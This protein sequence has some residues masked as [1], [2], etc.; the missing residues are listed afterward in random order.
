MAYFV[1]K[2]PTFDSSRFDMF[3]TIPHFC[4]SKVGGVMNERGLNGCVPHQHSPVAMHHRQTSHHRHSGKRGMEIIRLPC[5]H[6]MLRNKRII[7][8]RSTRFAYSHSNC[9]PPCC[10]LRLSEHTM[11]SNQS[12]GDER[13][14]APCFVP[15]E[16]CQSPEWR[17]P[18]H[19]LRQMKRTGC[20]KSPTC[21]LP[22]PLFSLHSQCRK[23]HY[24]T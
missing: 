23:I 14:E 4:R 16:S 3:E 20:I 17:G 6:A 15:P 18:H 1:E 11:V 21:I 9:G 24:S 10:C 12:H 8:W 19:F 13:I 2:R 22:E 5:I 7:S